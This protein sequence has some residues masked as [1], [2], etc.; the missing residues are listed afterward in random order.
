M[1][2]PPTIYTCYILPDGGWE[3]LNLLDGQH[4]RD[5]YR[6]LLELSI[7]VLGGEPKRGVFIARPGAL[8][9]ARWMAKIIYA[10]KVFLFRNQGTFKLTR[11][12]LS[13]IK[14]FVELSVS[15]YV[16]PWY[17]AP[18]PTAAPRKT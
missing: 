2:A 9:C 8:H 7:I 17:K 3:R 13:K 4:P 10:I 11:N 16:A 6:E 14:W 1:N 5:D 12:K 15:T 18:N